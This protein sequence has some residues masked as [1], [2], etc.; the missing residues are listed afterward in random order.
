MDLGRKQRRIRND[1]VDT[2]P[3]SPYKDRMMSVWPSI[4]VLDRQPVEIIR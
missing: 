2:A 3:S 1:P 4:P